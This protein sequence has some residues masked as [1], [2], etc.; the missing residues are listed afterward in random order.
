MELKLS[1]RIAEDLAL[2][3]YRELLERSLNQARLAQAGDRKGVAS[4]QWQR[5]VWQFVIR[6]VAH[7]VEG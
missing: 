5:R 7:E 3:R 1:G 6:R 4:K 2:E